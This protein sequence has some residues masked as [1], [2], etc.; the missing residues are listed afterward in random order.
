MAFVGITFEDFIRQWVTACANQKAEDD[1]R[2]TVLAIFGKSGFSQIIPAIDLK[3]K[4]RYIIKYNVNR[5]APRVY[6]RG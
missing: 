5:P 4:G 1:L 3:V 2:V 6:V